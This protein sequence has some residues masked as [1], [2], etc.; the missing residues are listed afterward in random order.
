MCERPRSSLCRSYSASASCERPGRRRRLSE[1]AFARRVTEPARR[2]RRHARRAEIARR[3]LRAMRRGVLE[4]RGHTHVL[5]ERVQDVCAAFPRRRIEPGTQ[6][7]RGRRDS[8][9]ARHDCSRMVPLRSYARDGARRDARIA[10]ERVSV[11][12]CGAV[13]RAA[14]A[15]SRRHALR[16]DRSG[17]A[18][19]RRAG[20][21][22]AFARRGDS[23]SRARARRRRVEEPVFDQRR[24]RATVGGDDD[25]QARDVL[26][27]NGG[28]RRSRTPSVGEIRLRVPDRAGAR[29]AVRGAARRLRG[30]RAEADARGGARSRARRGREVS[31]RGT[32]RGTPRRARRGDGGTPRGVRR[33]R[34]TLRVGRKRSRVDV[35]DVGDVRIV[36]NLLLRLS[37]AS[38][39]KP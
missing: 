8:A 33:R 7:F 10:H 29:H 1:P 11:R 20:R 22:R 12:R 18:E 37:S 9:R 17:V 4:V 27:R 14:R 23:R 39:V 3:Q 28:E 26:E 16:A 24:A 5:R 21:R 32:G 13:G 6:S 30:V 38:D 19:S 36:A 25:V 34:R 35:G 15:A 2:R 31:R